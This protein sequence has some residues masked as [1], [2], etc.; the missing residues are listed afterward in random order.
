MQDHNG[1]TPCKGNVV[2]GTPA[3]GGLGRPA[4]LRSVRRKARTKHARRRAGTSSSTRSVTSTGQRAGMAPRLRCAT[5]E[6]RMRG[7]PAPGRAPPRPVGLNSML[8]CRGWRR[9][10]AERPGFRVVHYSVQDDHA[11]FLVEAAGIEPTVRPAR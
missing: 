9:R 7:R 2:P 10:R 5:R 4:P 11:H 3:S 1:D 6:R 8:V